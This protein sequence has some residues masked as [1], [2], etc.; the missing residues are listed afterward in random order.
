MGQRGVWRDLQG[1]GLQVENKGGLRGQRSVTKMWAPRP[2][3][4]FIVWA[5]SGRHLT[6]NV[7][8]FLHL[9]T[10]VTTQTSCNRRLTDVRWVCR[11]GPNSTLTLSP[12]GGLCAPLQI[13][14][15]RLRDV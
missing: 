11:H 1:P 5:I 10:G 14:R 15:P 12:W 13:K 8:Q 9:L 3:V 2:V 4:L 6:L 7:P